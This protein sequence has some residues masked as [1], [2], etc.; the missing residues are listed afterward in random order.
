MTD[1]PGLQ[2]SD[3]APELPGSSASPGDA[4]VGLLRESFAAVDNA[5]KIDPPR[6]SLESLAGSVGVVQAGQ[7]LSYANIATS[8]PR[9]GGMLRSGPSGSV[10]VLAPSAAAK[11]GPLMGAFVQP[12]TAPAPPRRVPF[13]SANAKI[14]PSPIEGGPPG[15]WLAVSPKHGFHATVKSFVGAFGSVRAT[16]LLRA[17]FREGKTTSAYAYLL[18]ESGEA[19]LARIHSV[20]FKLPDGSPARL[21]RTPDE[22]PRTSFAAPVPRGV[23]YLDVVLAKYRGILPGEVGFQPYYDHVYQMMGT[24]GEILECY[25][26]QVGGLFE[27]EIHFRIRASTTLVALNQMLA[28][29]PTLSL[30]FPEGNGSFTVQLRWTPP[31]GK[32][33]KC[34]VGNH[35]KW[36]C[37][38]KRAEAAAM[39]AERL[40]KVAIAG[41]KDG[42]EVMGGEPKEPAVEDAGLLKDDVV[43]EPVV[44]GE[45]ETFEELV[46][47]KVAV[48]DESALSSEERDMFSAEEEA[49]SEDADAEMDP[50]DQFAGVGPDGKPLKPKK[51]KKVAS[52]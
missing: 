28:D 15:F 13:I 44:S 14:A 8:S 21:L 10:Y 40:R 50:A 30:P 6:V 49:G 34:K 26:P 5:S 32:C 52:K 45:I 16:V 41:D 51:N 3:R 38:K 11:A 23:L 18:V 48:A 27:R 39:L 7:Q 9:E 29:R 35:N 1:P 19:D 36:E 42:D 25:M 31:T 46:A 33:W 37:D 22:G 47:G 43:L 17:A 20:G 12:A 24:Y 2:G 4:G